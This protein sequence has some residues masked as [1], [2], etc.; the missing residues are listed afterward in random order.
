MAFI[1]RV[2]LNGFLLALVLPQI[3]TDIHFTGQIWPEGIIAGLLFAV[4]VW[5]VDLLLKIFGVMTLGLGFILKWML[6]FLIPA[7]QLWAMS[8]MFPQFLTI[9]SIGSGILAGLIL[10]LVNAM[11]NSTPTGKTTS[12]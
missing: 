5:F 1:L 9:G 4:V 2:A 11:T 12:D 6:W 10:M 7:L 8:A 3:F